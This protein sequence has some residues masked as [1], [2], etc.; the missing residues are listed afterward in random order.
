MLAYVRPIRVPLAKLVVVDRVS[1]QCIATNLVSH[2]QVQ[3][4]EGKEWFGVWDDDGDGLLTY[5]VE[6]ENEEADTIDPESL[7]LCT[8]FEHNGEYFLK[9]RAAWAIE[10]P[11]SQMLAPG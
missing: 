3:L 4:P 9:D 5:P 6:N 8:V 7:F 2:E 1:D 11:L 10:E